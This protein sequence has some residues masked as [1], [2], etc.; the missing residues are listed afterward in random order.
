MEHAASAIDCHLV[1]DDLVVFAAGGLTDIDR[2]R[3]EAHRRGCAHCT[4][5]IEVLSAIVDAFSL[6]VPDA[7]PPESLLR[8]I[9]TAVDPEYLQSANEREPIAGTPTGTGRKG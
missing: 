1:Q 3:V 2:A 7:I 5:E 9:M 4:T 6:A 8:R